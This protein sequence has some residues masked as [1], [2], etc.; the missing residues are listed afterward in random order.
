MGACW[1]W[2]EARLDSIGCSTGRDTKQ[3][4]ALLHDLL[5]PDDANHAAVMTMAE[6]VDVSDNDSDMR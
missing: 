3:L 6:A 5:T 2:W 4:E 1:L